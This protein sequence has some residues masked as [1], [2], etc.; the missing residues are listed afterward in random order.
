M[1]GGR[2]GLDLARALRRRFPGLPVLLT[3][4]Y[5]AAAQQ[6]AAEGFPVLPKPYQRNA[7][8]SAVHAAFLR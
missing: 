2:N 5:S 6:A 1:P 8:E 7:L 3:T 4:G